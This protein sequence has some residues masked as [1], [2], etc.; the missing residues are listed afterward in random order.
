[1]GKKFLVPWWYRG[2]L[3]KAN[4]TPYIHI[5]CYHL[6]FFLETSGVKRFTGQGVEKTNDVL[7]RLYQPR[8]QA[9]P[10]C[11]GKTLVDAGHMTHGHVTLVT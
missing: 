10:F 11:G 8:T 7:R 4:V 2:R 5:L 1:M 9:L 6:P 3:C